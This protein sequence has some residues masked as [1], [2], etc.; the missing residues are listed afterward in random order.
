M[1]ESFG[2]IYDGGGGDYSGVEYRHLRDGFAVEDGFQVVGGHHL[3]V[4]QVRRP[5][6]VGDR[7][8]EGRGGRPQRVLGDH[9]LD[10]DR[11]VVGDGLRVTDDGGASVSIVGGEVH[12]SRVP[13]LNDWQCERG[14]PVFVPLIAGR[15]GGTGAHFL[16]SDSK[17]DRIVFGGFWRLCRF[18]R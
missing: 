5:V 6:G 10:V 7:E 13:R 11:V 16:V 9:R 18:R 8:V 17:I 3:T 4:V 12:R 14:I 15:S 2:Q 1:G